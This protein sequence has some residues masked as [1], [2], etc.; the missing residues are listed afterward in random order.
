MRDLLNKLYENFAMVLMV[1]FGILAVLG[2]KINSIDMTVISIIALFISPIISK[3][4]VKLIE[5]ME[6]L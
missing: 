4:F 1:V 3:M 6:E 2:F 5:K